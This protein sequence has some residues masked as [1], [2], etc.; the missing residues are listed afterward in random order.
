MNKIIL[1]ALALCLCASSFAQN[2]KVIE[3]KNAETRNV[4]GFHAIRVSSGIDLYLTQSNEEAVAVSATEPDYRDRIK[5]EVE[6]GVLRIYFENKGFSWNWGNK[7]LKAYVSIKN[8][9]GLDASGGSDIYLQGSI[10]SENLHVD[11]SGGSDMKGRVEVQTMSIRQTGGSDVD[12]T[13][14]VSNMTVDA[15]GGSDLNGYDLVTEY[16]KIKASGGS[17]SHLTV[18]KELSANASGGSDI[19]YK[20]TGVVREVKFSGSSG[21]T[22]KG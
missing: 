19:Y 15:S 22:K 4:K 8:I 9:D 6:D 7:K 3:D 2:A 11:L 16:C 17:D 5:T 10:K 20:G 21:V 1:S 14:S 12:L 18:N 13:G